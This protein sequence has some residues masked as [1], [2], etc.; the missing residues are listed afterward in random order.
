MRSR[1]YTGW[2]EHHRTRPVRNEFRYQVYFLLT[3]LAELDDWAARSKVLGRDRGLLRLRDRDHGPRDG[4][5]LRPWI[6]T[7]LAA[8]SIDLAGGSV[9]LLAFPRSLGFGFYPAS[10][11]YCYHADGR[12]RAILVEVQNTYGEHH[13]YL[14]HDG[15]APMDLSHR[16]TVNKV[17]HVSPFIPMDA[18][19]RFHFTDPG[20]AFAEGDPLE[21][22]IYDEVEGS[23][24]LTAGI[25]LEAREATD[26]AL[27]SIVSTL[28]PMPLRAGALIGYQA[29]RLLAKGVKWLPHP[30]TTA[31]ETTHD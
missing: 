16:P 11:W 3:D 13:N 15:G 27:R 1:L 12:L 23:L 25:A 2:V 28:G 6:D 20:L 18:R 10:F 5:P 30:Q 31:Q 21:I 8:D 9:L 14:L 22:R 4:T 7:V 29:L 24:L 17:F 19:Y 26:E